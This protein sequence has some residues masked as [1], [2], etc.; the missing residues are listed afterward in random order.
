MVLLAA[1]VVGTVL[2]FL[3]SAGLAGVTALCTTNVRKWRRVT[4]LMA[5]GLPFL[6]LVWGSSIFFLQWFVNDVFLH[7][8]ANLG[9]VWK[10]PLP[11]GYELMMIDVTDYGWVYNPRTQIGE[12][13][14]AEQDD[15]PFGVRVLQLHGSYIF[16]G[17]DT[18]IRSRTNDKNAHSID[19]YFLL[20]TQAHTRTDFQTYDSLLARASQLG[21][22]LKLEPIATVYSR[23]RFTWFDYL[24]D[25]LFI[26]PPIAAFLV[27]IWWVIRLRKNTIASWKRHSLLDQYR[28]SDV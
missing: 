28:A 18:K 2:A 16:G 8:D 14:V 25:T 1:A 22:S 24:M 27:F 19:S 20:D 15:A 4:I 21:I 11:N 6:T 5:A 12:Y 9:D 17:V 13:D 10:T 7:R 26:V 3:T 23:Y